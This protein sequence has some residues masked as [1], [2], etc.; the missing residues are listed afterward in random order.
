MR[1]GRGWG[2]KIG[3]KREWSERE[4]Q[5]GEVLV[6]NSQINQALKQTSRL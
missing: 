5:G 6:E 3:G 2:R 4:T 1:G